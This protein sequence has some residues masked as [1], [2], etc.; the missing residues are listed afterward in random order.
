MRVIFMSALAVG[1]SKHSAAFSSMIGRHRSSLSCGHFPARI[2]RGFQ[3]ARHVTRRGPLASVLVLG[4]LL[5]AG[6]PA[7]AAEP[8]TGAA[9]GDKVSNSNSLR[10]LRG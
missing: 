1:R 5:G 3:E 4:M 8:A 2:R 10:D 6:R 9:V 7:E